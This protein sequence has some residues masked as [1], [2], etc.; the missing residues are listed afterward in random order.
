MDKS[1]INNCTNTQ[2]T[3]QSESVFSKKCLM[4]LVFCNFVLCGR[5]VQNKNFIMKGNLLCLVI[6]VTWI[7]N[8]MQNEPLNLHNYDLYWKIGPSFAPKKLQIISKL[9]NW[10]FQNTV[11]IIDNQQQHIVQ[12]HIDSTRYRSYRS[13]VF[14]LLNKQFVKHLIN[15]TSFAS[16]CNLHCTT[17]ILL[18]YGHREKSQVLLKKITSCNMLTVVITYQTIQ[19]AIYFFKEQHHLALQFVSSETSESSKI[20]TIVSKNFK[21][22]LYVQ[23]V[24][25]SNIMHCVAKSH[26]CDPLTHYMNVAKDYYNITFY[27]ESHTS[28]WDVYGAFVETFVGT[29]KTEGKIYF[30]NEHKVF[31]IADEQYKIIYC[32]NEQTLELESITY[33]VAPYEC[34]I[35]ILALISFAILILMAYKINVTLADGVL[36]LLRFCLRQDHPFDKKCLI[37][38]SFT[39]MILSVG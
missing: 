13:V 33:L 2:N 34:T 16:Y 19:N 10:N 39:I 23:P 12:L 35:W 6:I 24:L 36:I 22:K 3:W 38:L 5:L 18:S 15:K 27:Q 37:Y 31:K 25:V 20:K 7:T 14:D 11:Q 26:I 28:T 30:M 21:H 17:Y 32:E 8:S 29:K 9:S 1:A 4:E